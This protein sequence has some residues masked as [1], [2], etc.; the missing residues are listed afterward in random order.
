MRPL[1]TSVSIFQA[2]QRNKKIALSSIYWDFNEF[3]IYGRSSNTEKLLYRYLDEFFVEKVKDFLRIDH[4]KYNIKDIFKYY[5]KS[6]K[7]N[8]MN[9]DIFLPNSTGEGKI[10]IKKIYKNAKYHVVNNAVDKDIFYLN[11]SQNRNNNAMIAARID[12]RKN[13]LNLVKAI[14]NRKLNIYGSPSNFHLRYFNK[15]K[16]EIDN[17]I[18]LLGHVN[19]EELANIYNSHLIH[20]LP[21]W[22]ETP[23]LSQLEAAACGCNI[24][25]TNKGSTIEYFGKMAQYCD[26]SSTTSIKEALESSYDNLIP[27]KN[28]SDYILSKYTWEK[29]AQQTLEAYESILD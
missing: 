6:Y 25:S 24:V 10:L 7:K 28:M 20:I 22:L 21:S 29:T 1:E 14:K 27:P 17:N 15:I 18:N 4:G 13:I 11:N 12:P 2:K 19:P 3:N 23:G 9:V 16:N 5:A 8:M 26:P